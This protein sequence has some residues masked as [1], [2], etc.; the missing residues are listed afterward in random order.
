MKLTINGLTK[1]IGIKQIGIKQIGTKQ[2][3]IKTDCYKT[4]W[5]TKTDGIQNMICTERP[6]KIREI[7]AYLNEFLLTAIISSHERMVRSEVV[8]LRFFS[9]HSLFSTQFFSTQF[10]FDTVFFQGEARRGDAPGDAPFSKRD[11]YTVFRYD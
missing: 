3:G 11:L 6:K 2:I 7:C 1:R 8:G 5:Y 9:R 10:F 4:D